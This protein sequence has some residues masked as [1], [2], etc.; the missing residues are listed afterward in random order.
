MKRLVSVFTCCLYI[1]HSF[2]IAF[3]KFVCVCNSLFQ[4]GAVNVTVQ[5]PSLLQAS[6]H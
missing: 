6:G 2:N 4:Y 5:I 1:I 3:K